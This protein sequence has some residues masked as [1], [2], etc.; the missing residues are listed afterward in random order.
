MTKIVDGTSNRLGS[1]YTNYRGE[2]SF[3]QPEG[4][5][6]YRVTATYKNSTVTKDIE[7]TT[8]AIYRMALN[9]DTNREEKP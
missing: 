2:F 3:S 4:V 6:K 9:L 8:A 7:V 1:G 5:T